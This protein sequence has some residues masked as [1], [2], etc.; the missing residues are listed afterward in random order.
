MSSGYLGLIAA[1][2]IEASDVGYDVA[3]CLYA[4]PHENVIA[5]PS[6]NV[7]R[8]QLI[9]RRSYFQVS[10]LLE[11]ILAVNTLSNN[12][13]GEAPSGYPKHLESK[14]QGAGAVVRIGEWFDFLD[15]PS[16]TYVADSGETRVGN[17]G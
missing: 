5:R 12:P 6:Q 1:P 9:P 15:V 7:R 14:S 11:P 17:N 13:T 3:F 4:A 10:N 8:L 2:K 16:D